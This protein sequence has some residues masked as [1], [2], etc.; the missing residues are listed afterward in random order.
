MT[1]FWR[2]HWADCP[3]FNA[4]HAWSALWGTTRTP[5]GT[6]T[7]CVACDGTGQGQRDCPACNGTGWLDWDD[8][9]TTCDGSGQVDGCESCKGEG[10]DDC[11]RGYS[12]FTEA[13]SLLDYFATP[14]RGEPADNDGKVILFE[15]DHQGTGFDGEDLAVPTA[16]VK[17]MT[18]SEFLASQNPTN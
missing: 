12:C 17:E 8:Q 4:E 16:I 3:E 10:V 9:C 11:Q 14:A 13:E 6:H 18:W 5:D 15:G 7:Y 2:F 1:T